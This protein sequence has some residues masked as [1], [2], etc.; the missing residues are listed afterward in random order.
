MLMAGVLYI[1]GTL[2]QLFSCIGVYY[3][4]YYC[5]L[6]VN[7]APQHMQNNDTQPNDTKHND[8]KPNDTE[9]NA[10]EPNDTKPNDTKPNDTKPNDTNS[11]NSTGKPPNS[12]SQQS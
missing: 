3:I 1:F 4:L 9:P 6:F 5:V 8:I 7:R 2:R 10:T 12:K 11:A